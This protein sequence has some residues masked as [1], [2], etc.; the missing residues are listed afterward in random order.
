MLLGDL[1]AAQGDHRRAVDTWARIES[2]NPAFLSLVAERIADGYRRLGEAEQGR[3][4]L[5]NYLEHYP[6]LDL[7]NAAYEITRE[8]GG[9]DAAAQ[10]VKDELRRHPTLPGLDKLMEAEMLSAPPERRQE[11]ELVKTLVSQHTR[12]LGM[13]R[14]DSCGFRAKSYYWRCPGCGKWESYQPR[15]TETPDGYS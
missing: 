15:R 6:S 5:E 13:Y 1:A 8:R 10:L 7:L 14:C 4:V 2:Q 12:R 11:M 3:R 9:T